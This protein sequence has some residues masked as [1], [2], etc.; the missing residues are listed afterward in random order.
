MSSWF[1]L[2]GVKFEFLGS[3]DTLTT[4]LNKL[5]PFVKG[6]TGPL[7][8]VY[9]FLHNQPVPIMD[10]LQC[11]LMDQYS[12]HGGYSW[13]MLLGRLAKGELIYPWV[14]SRN[15]RDQLRKQF[16]AAQHWLYQW[17]YK[18]SERSRDRNVVFTAV[19]WQNATDQNS[20]TCVVTN[21]AAWLPATVLP[22][23]RLLE[24]LAMQISTDY[25]TVL[26]RKKV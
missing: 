10:L 12:D 3:S 18:F 4:D 24:P 2:G 21:F 20:G 16:S 8:A 19:G 14:K 23:F 17:E 11:Q 5:Q 25:T 15:L 9:L 26:L 7:S 22:L 6:T 1:I 13:P